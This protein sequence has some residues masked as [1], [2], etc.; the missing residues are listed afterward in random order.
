MS[1]CRHKRKGYTFCSPSCW[2]EHLAYA[3][4]RES[5]AEDFQ[6]PTK[7]EAF[8]SASSSDEPAAPKRRVIV[9]DKPTTSAGTP[10]TKGIQTDTLV[11]VS[12]VKKLIKDRSGMSTSQCC[13]D[14]LTQKVIEEA[15]KG[16]EN[17][18]AAERKTV[19]GRDIK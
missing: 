13:V 18:K 6:S 5:W 3:N 4:H 12:K 14:Q 2:S 7:A 17:A 11:V 16:I 1:T 8:G 19:M 9:S 15:L 10:S